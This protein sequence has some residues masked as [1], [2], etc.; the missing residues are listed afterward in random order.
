MSR[1]RTSN[2]HE[3]SRESGGS[4]GTLERSGLLFLISAPS[5]TGKTTV[6]DGLLKTHSHLSRIITCTTRLPREGEKDGVDYHFLTAEAFLKRVQAGNF[7]EHA[8]VFGNSYGVLKSEVLETLRSGSDVLLT[9]DVQGAATIREQSEK[10]PELKK[11]LVTLFLA[12]PNMRELEARLRNRNKDSDATIQK[13]LSV[14]RQE[15]A[16]SRHFDYI[17][18]SESI[19]ADLSR[20]QSILEAERLRQGRRPLPDYDAPHGTSSP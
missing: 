2:R 12:P 20:V 7:L 10:D 15:I 4:A 9:V 11:A 18:V 17:L 16:Q 13:R 1:S 3:A 14:A 5:G 6:C 19:D 8:T